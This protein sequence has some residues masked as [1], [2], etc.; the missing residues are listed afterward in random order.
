MS[1]WVSEFASLVEAMDLGKQF[2]DETAI[3][4]MGPKEETDS[5]QQDN[6]DPRK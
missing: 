5:K 3:E 4:R 1:E 2:E 6:G